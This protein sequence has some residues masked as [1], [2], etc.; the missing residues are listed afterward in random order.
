VSRRP[1]VAALVVSWDHIMRYIL[2]I[3]AFLFQVSGVVFAKDK[4][5]A[6]DFA[7]KYPP[8]G[9]LNCINLHTNAARN[10]QQTNFLVVT[11]FYRMD[12]LGGDMLRY[13]VTENGQ[14][15]NSID[16]GTGAAGDLHRKQLSKAE[17]ERLRSAVEKLPRT[18][19]YPWLSSLVIVSHRDG[20]NWV[21]H[22]YA[23]HRSADDPPE[24]PALR[25]LLDTL[26]EWREAQEVH[27]F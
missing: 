24:A 4:E 15:V 21:T 22:S 11:E 2:G 9:F 8:L 26:G 3:L 25:E 16:G 5:S 6:P 20:T 7:E 14:T 10:L 23:R 19:Q 1:G 27:S 12:R 17:V 18:N 13:V